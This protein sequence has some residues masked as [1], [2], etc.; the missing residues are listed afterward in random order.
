MARAEYRQDH[1][2]NHEHTQRLQKSFAKRMSDNIAFAMVAYTLMLIFMV[3]PKLESTG[4]S[5]FP[6]FILVFL[7]G[8]AIPYGHKLERRWDMLSA[9]EL[10]TSGL[11]TRFAIDRII[12]WIAAIGVPFLLSFAAG[13]MRGT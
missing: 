2:R 13:A 10:G 1:G 6:Y 3:T 11:N 4:T 12:L 9:S 8:C 5:I 7:V